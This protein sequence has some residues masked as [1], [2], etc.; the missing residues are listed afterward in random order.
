M[1]RYVLLVVLTVL[2]VFCGVQESRAG[3]II[4]TIDRCT[5]LTVEDRSSFILVHDLTS[6]GQD[7]L[8]VNSSNVMINLNGFAVIGNGAARG[9]TA[10]SSA[11]GVTV[12]NGAIRGFAIGLSLGGMGNVVES[13]HVE[14]NTDTGMFLGASSSVRNAVVQG[15]WQHGAILSTAGSFK[16]SLVR[17]NG[18]TPASVGVSAGPG[19]TITGNTI[20]ANTGTGLFGSIGGTVIGNT[21]TDTIGAGISVI[22]PANIQQNTATANTGGNLVQAGIGCLAVNNVAP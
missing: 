5:E 1:R 12:R 11:H 10:H 19:S 16:D 20:W 22:C 2:G 9:I 8:V 6:F 13:V 17:A 15:N 7:C 14:N 21:V 4:R 3:D 18:N